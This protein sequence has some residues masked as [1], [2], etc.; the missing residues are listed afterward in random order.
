MK[1]YVDVASTGVNGIVDDAAR[2]TWCYFEIRRFLM[3]SGRVVRCAVGML[4]MF[5]EQTTSSI[6]E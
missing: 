5:E 1:G 4:D 3:A 6:R 2:G